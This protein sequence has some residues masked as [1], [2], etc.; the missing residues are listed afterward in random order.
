[1]AQSLSL[2]LWRLNRTQITQM[3]MI[4]NDFFS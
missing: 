1:M 2:R 3:I 4:E